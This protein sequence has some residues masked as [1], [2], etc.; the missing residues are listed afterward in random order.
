MRTI[1]VM[2]VVIVMISIITTN[3]VAAVTKDHTVI[4][5]VRLT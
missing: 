3:T 2:T 5:R 4:I 1:I